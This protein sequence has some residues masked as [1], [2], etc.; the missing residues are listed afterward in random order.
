MIETYLMV[1]EGFVEFSLLL[2]D[3]EAMMWLEI[4]ELRSPIIGGQLMGQQ[5]LFYRS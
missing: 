5:A 3:L 2:G 1:E 4:G